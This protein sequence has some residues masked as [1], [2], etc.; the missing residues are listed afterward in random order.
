MLAETVIDHNG[1]RIRQVLNVVLAVALP[2]AAVLAFFTG[3][4]FEEA[5]RS[6]AGCQSGGRDEARACRSQ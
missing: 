4:S 3:T 5:T 6:E 1:D 2:V